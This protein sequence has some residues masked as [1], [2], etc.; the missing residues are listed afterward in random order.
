MTAFP[1]VTN[2]VKGYD[3]HEVDDFF[4]RARSLYEVSR[5]GSNPLTSGQI[6]EVSFRLVRGGYSSSHVDDALD[7]LET[8][9]AEHERNLAIVQYGERSWLIGARETAD[10]IALRLG[11]KPRQ[12]FARSSVF[13]Q[14]YR[15]RDV[16]LFA[17]A[18]LDYV[19]SGKPMMVSHVRSVTFRAQR[20]GYR[21]DQV[22]ALLDALVELMLAG[23]QR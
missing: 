6:R 17:S 23:G 9:L 22:D 12:R 13:D 10:E 5:E 8:A 14:G 21:E 15:V 3:V 1:R 11:R 20:G 2:R 7:R 4:E 19:G 16:D 18:I